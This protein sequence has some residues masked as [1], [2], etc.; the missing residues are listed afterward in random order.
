MSPPPGLSLPVLPIAFSVLYYT[1]VQF[2]YL[3]IAFTHSPLSPLSPASYYAAGVM[4]YF[5]IPVS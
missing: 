4:A 1:I 5:C 2:G 3:Y